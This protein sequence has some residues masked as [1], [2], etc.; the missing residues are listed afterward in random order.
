MAS[1]LLAGL[2]GLNLLRLAS[3]AAGSRGSC[4]A[5]C[6]QYRLPNHLQRKLYLTHIYLG[7]SERAEIRS[8]SR[9]APRE[10]NEN[11]ITL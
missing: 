7:L 4:P 6:R 2:F 10:F 11:N 9:Y 1:G 8:R 5:P 3:L